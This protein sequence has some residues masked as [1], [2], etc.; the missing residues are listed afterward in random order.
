MNRFMNEKFQEGLLV[1]YDLF[2]T[3]I[4]SLSFNTV[5]ISKP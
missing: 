2:S 4:R 1:K 5:T 3:K